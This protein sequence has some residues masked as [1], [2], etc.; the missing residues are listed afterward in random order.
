MH[1]RASS[2]FYN[3][4][5]LSLS[6]SFSGSCSIKIFNSNGGELPIGNALSISESLCPCDCYN[7]IVRL[8]GAFRLVR[9]LPQ[10]F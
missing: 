3:F 4:S 8:S 1:Y 6:V 5:V 9:P 10:H 2:S 7:A